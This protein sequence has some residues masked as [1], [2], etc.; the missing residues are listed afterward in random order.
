MTIAHPQGHTTLA[1]WPL[2]I[3]RALTA[4]AIDPNALLKIAGIDHAQLVQQPDGRIDIQ[5]MTHFWQLVLNTTQDES[6]GLKVAK[7]VLPMHF[8]A[9]GLLMLT[10]DNLETALLKLGEYSQLV[11]DSALTRLEQTPNLFGFCI[12][13]IEGVPISELAIDS[14]FA[15]LINFAMQ[16]GGSLN[17]INKVELMRPAPNC[18]E[19][20]Q[21][22]FQAPITFD[23]QHNC[24]WLNRQQLHQTHIMGDKNLAAY[25]ES[26]VQDYLSSLATTSLAHKVKTAI[27]RQL[28]HG[29]PS[30]IQIAQQLNMSERSLRRHLQDEH[31]N[32]RDILKSVRMEIA[33]KLLSQPQTN[34]TEIS[35]RL[36]FTDTSNFSR[37]FTQWFHMSPSQYR[38]QQTS[39]P[40]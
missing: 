36:G 31:A 25:N 1:A 39:K 21:Q 17:I 32:Y 38:Q 2:A 7:F 34:M 10:S 24:L 40:T 29:E 27:S 28:E 20:W 26:Q 9:L 30:L 35:Q 11:S 13:P 6:F 14:F 3:C 37:A 19:N 16:L 22:H 8:R 4:Q 33:L 18:A 15:T 23:A 5:R 12:D